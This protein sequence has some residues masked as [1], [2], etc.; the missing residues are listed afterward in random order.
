[1]RSRTFDGA[2]HGGAT[3]AGASLP[4]RAFSGAV[5]AALTIEVV[6]VV[7]VVGALVLFTDPASLVKAVSTPVAQSAIK[8]TLVTVTISSALSVLLAVPAAYGLAFWRIPGRA[9]VDTVV[10][11]PIVMP[12]IAAGLALL[13]LFGYYLGDPMRSVGL[14]LPYTQAG[15]VVA[16]FFGTMTFAVRTTKAAF[17][18]VGPRLPAVAGSLGSTPWRTFSRVT[19]PLAR[20]GL[21][22]G[23]VLTWARCIGLFG[24]VVM[25]CGVTQ[26]RTEVL[27]TSIY[28]QNS[29]GN[30]EVA[31]AGTLILLFIA[32]LTLVVFKRLGGRGYLW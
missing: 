2:G 32:L 19:L 1:M 20:P 22:A 28:L 18:S 10:D 13:L 6:F 9:L 8:L 24:P 26:Y 12:P 11:L 23:A 15:I 25:F 3:S 21:I 14:Y 16:Q 29:I 4:D 31:A 17:E 27:S 30:L 5:V 7:G